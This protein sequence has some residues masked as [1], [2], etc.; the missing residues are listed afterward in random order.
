MRKKLLHS[1]ALLSLILTPIILI[2]CTKK[3]DWVC[4][5]QV[6]HDTTTVHETKEIKNVRKPDA[7]RLCA[8]FGEDVS[9]KGSVH[10]CQVK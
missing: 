3:Y 6:Y 4:T 8:K 9:P 10:E 5:C 2:S 7:D 1:P